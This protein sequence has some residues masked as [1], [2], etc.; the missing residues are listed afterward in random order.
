MTF[1]I[2]YGTVVWGDDIDMGEDDIYD[3]MFCAH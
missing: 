3:Q 2:E 1:R